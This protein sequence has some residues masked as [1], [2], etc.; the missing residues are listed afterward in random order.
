MIA[1]DE[2]VAP[3]LK[4]FLTAPHGW[5]IALLGL[6]GVL[7]PSIAYGQPGNT[8]QRP[9][10]RWLPATAPRMPPYWVAPPAAS[11]PN[12]IT[13]TTLAV[14]GGVSV[15]GGAALFSQAGAVRSD[16]RFD[17]LSECGRREDNLPQVAGMAMMS[18]GA[19]IAIL[20]STL[21]LL[22]SADPLTYPHTDSELAG[23]G[24][25]LA[26]GALGS[27]VG[28]TASLLY[29][30]EHGDDNVGLS[31]AMFGGAALLLPLGMPTW[32][33]G[34]SG[35]PLAL[36]VTNAAREGTP[37][38]HHVTRSPTMMATGVAFMVLGAAGLGA[39]V[40]VTMAISE[41]G[42]EISDDSWAFSSTLMTTT[43]VGFIGAGIPLLVV[44][45]AQVTP[46]EAFV[47]RRDEEQYW[48]PKVAVGPGSFS[49]SWRTP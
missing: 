37:K 33:R 18:S 34:A 7:T 2:G 35:P 3:G 15:I 45:S 14:M 11:N 29:A 5:L 49:M 41:G 9:D 48:L 39:T 6:L 10:A 13:G 40:G 44:G 30:L 1:I 24:A 46:A 21:A 27:F 23:A 38:V 8:S 4:M 17:F 16:C 20:G 43:S 42:S 26:I 31:Y 19:T 12:V 47:Y 32:F 22:G 28:G 25:G 36:H